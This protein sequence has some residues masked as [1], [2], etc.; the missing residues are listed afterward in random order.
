MN[1]GWGKGASGLVARLEEMKGHI[2]DLKVV[3]RQQQEE[4]ADHLFKVIETAKYMDARN[5]AEMAKEEKK[6]NETQEEKEDA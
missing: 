6:K 4:T 5:R 1:S 3:V 2:E